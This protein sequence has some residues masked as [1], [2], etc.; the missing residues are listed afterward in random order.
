MEG[1]MTCT[2]CGTPMK[3]RCENYRYDAVGL[4]GI[5]LRDVEVSRCPKCGEYEVAIPRIEEL[6]R[7]IAQ[8]L[9]AKRERLTPSEIRFLRKFLGWSGVDFA[10]HVGTTPETVSRWETGST[11]MGVTADRLLRLMVASRQPA[12]DYSL[13]TLKVVAREQ[14]KPIR[15]RME[16]DDGQWRARAA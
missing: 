11:P 6:H 10:A 16:V 13:D 3:T 9:I 14:A 2:V 8:A 4:P 12:T 5:T 7:T 15:L 1:E